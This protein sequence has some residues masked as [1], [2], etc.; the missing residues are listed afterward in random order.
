M[1]ILLLHFRLLGHD[2]AMVFHYFLSWIK[3]ILHSSMTF[4]PGGMSTLKRLMIGSNT[5]KQESEIPIK[6]WFSS[7]TNLVSPLVPV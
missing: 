2:L 3:P 5:E 1:V 6:K 7:S 4:W